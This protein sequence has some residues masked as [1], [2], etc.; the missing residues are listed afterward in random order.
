MLLPL[1]FVKKHS[2]KLKAGQEKSILQLP[3]RVI[4]ATMISMK[5]EYD[6]DKN[7]KN[8]K[9]RGLSFDGVANF[10][11]ETAIRWQDTRKEY[12]EVRYCALG[13]ISDR[14]H[15]VVYV[16]IDGGIRVISFRK[17]NKREVK[18][19]ESHTKS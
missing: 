13:R 12:G 4:M 6:P 14:V 11:F 2:I 1:Y 15:V 18:R 17:A 3:F 19:Y 8:I 9:T 5:I 7:R 16:R 10:E